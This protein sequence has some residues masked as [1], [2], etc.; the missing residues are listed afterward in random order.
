M[1]YSTNCFVAE[2]ES[3]DDQLTQIYIPTR[4]YGERDHDRCRSALT[5]VSVL[6]VAAETLEPKEKEEDDKKVTEAVSRGARMW[7]PF[8]STISAKGYRFEPH[9]SRLH[10]SN[11]RQDRGADV[12]GQQWPGAVN[13]FQLRRKR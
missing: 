12:V 5:T 9:P 10:C 7:T 3:V 8:I 1:R 11:E 4:N 13:R 2:T 6:T